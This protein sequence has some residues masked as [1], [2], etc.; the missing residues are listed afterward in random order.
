MALVLKQTLDLLNRSPEFIKANNWRLRVMIG[1]NSQTSV[2]VL[3]Q[4]AEDDSA[5]VR[6][7]VS[8]NPNTPQ[9]TAVQAG[10]PD[11]FQQLLEEGAVGN[12]RKQ[13]EC[14]SASHSV[15]LRQAVASN[16][17]TPRRVMEVLSID[18]CPQVR[19]EL[20]RNQKTPERILEVL[21]NDSSACVRVSI[22]ANPKTPR[23]TKLKLCQDRNRRVQRVAIK[24]TYSKKW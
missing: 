18:Y 12:N 3:L 15:K 4:L 6:Y 24:Y 13:L 19:R 14:L 5:F 21:A 22:A 9:N 1:R 8:R 7:A 10:N 2:E 11:Y 16:P 17:N 20:A 23:N